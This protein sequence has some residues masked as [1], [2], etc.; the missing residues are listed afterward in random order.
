[1]SMGMIPATDINKLFQ[2]I[3]RG[4]GDI[5]MRELIEFLAYHGFQPTTEDLEAILRRCDHD[6]DRALSLEEF[7][8]ACGQDFAALIADRDMALLAYKEQKEKEIEIAQLSAQARQA[9]IELQMEDAR[10][11]REMRMME[12]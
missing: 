1:M 3:G 8:E 10:K 6:A 7:A 5:Q 11:A 12:I 9:E 2:D 4:Y